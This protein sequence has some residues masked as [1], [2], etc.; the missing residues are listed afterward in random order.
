[1]IGREGR[2]SMGLLLALLFCALAPAWA[3]P[4]GPARGALVLVGGAM[5]D[6]TILERFIELAGEVNL[7]MPEY[8][9]QK[10]EFGLDKEGKNFSTSRILLLGLAYKKNVDD[11]RESV[12]FKVMELLTKQGAQVDYNDPYIPFIKPR[13][14]YKQFIGE[15]SVA[16]ENIDQYDIAV[17]LTD[18]ST[19]DFEKI[20]EQ[21]KVVVDTR[22]A[23]GAIK[24]NKI[25]KA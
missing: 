18:H 2:V 13:R 20:V 3:Q 11:D 8:V 10:I 23:C 21:S 24:S 5:R 4:G 12:T 19:Y 1:M 22:N 25:I 17:I 14:E 6:P 16:L 15:K 7:S 9:V